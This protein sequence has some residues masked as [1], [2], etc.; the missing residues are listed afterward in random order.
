[1]EK[2]LLQK[3]TFTM[4]EK[5]C[6]LTYKIRTFKNKG[7]TLLIVWNI[8][9]MNLLY[10][11]LTQTSLEGVHFIA[12][13]FTLPI[14]G[15]LADV[16]LGRYKVIQWSMWIMW[17]GSMLATLSSVVAQSVDS[18]AS[19][20][21][22][23]T[24]AILVLQ[25]IGFAGYHANIYQFGV[26]QFPDA[27]TNA[28]R[29]FISWFIWTYAG[30]VAGHYIYGCIGK[31]YY[32]IGQCFI[33]I[34]LTITLITSFL[35]NGILI[36]EPVVQNP[37]KLVYKVIKYA[38]TNKHPQRRSAFTYCEDE[39]PP[40]I[41]FG[42]SKYGGPFTTEQVED[43]KT[44]LRVLAF[45]TFCSLVPGEAVIVS[46]HSHKL[47]GLISHRGNTSSECFVRKITSDFQ[48]L[49]G[50]ILIPIH[51]FIVYPLLHRYFYWVKSSYTFLF[52]EI[53]QIAR[54]VALEL[55][56]FEARHLHVRHYG[57]NMTMQCIFWEEDGAL[58]ATVD[59]WWMTIPN[60]L[61]SMSLIL[62]GVGAYE[63]IC[64]QTPYSMRGLIFGCANGSCAIFIL[65][66]YGISELFTRRLIN[67]GTG[68]ISCGFWYLLLIMLLMVVHTAI[69]L[70]LIKHYK[71]RK[72]EDVLPNEHIF[73]ERYYDKDSD[74]DI[75]P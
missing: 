45:M 41:D 4:R 65:I 40:R 51:E 12:L 30:C 68:T 60:I 73:A 32:V 71:R 20:S 23:V 13:L 11:L 24:A 37:Y 57:S 16:Y 36:K 52:G 47:I 69:L 1:M 28:I 25:V 7:A 44:F 18:Y 46:R 59:S 14:A 61:N 10:Y 19:I 43:V 54:I 64:A 15:W 39:L 62:L 6:Q 3:S 31:K 34:C 48:F 74:N 33:S 66:G 8:L 42:K 22:K 67:W 2:V 72:R 35:L 29:S 70:I 56:E 63:F 49:C 53:L 17:V 75:Q 27:S 38:L 9:V 26:D 21:E 58:S 50:I 5:Y 55:I